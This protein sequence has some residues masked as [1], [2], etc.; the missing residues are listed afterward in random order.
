VEE[1]PTAL[2]VSLLDWSEWTGAEWR[3]LPAGRWPWL[4]V[5]KPGA[6]SQ[7]R[8]RLRPLGSSGSFSLVAV[9]GYSTAEGTRTHSAVTLGPLRVVAGWRDWF[10]PWAVAIQSVVVTLLL[11]ITLVLVAWLLPVME[12]SWSESRAQAQQTWN[13][14][15]PY[16]MQTGR[17]HYLPVASTLGWLSWSVKQPEPSSP[18]ERAEYR[19]EIVYYTLRFL[20][21]M[22]D[23]RDQLGGLHF[24]NRKGEAAAA[25]CWGSI[26]D[27]LSKRFCLREY[28]AA[29]DAVNPKD[30]FDRFSIRLERRPIFRPALRRAEA[31]ITDWL[32]GQSGLALKEYLPLLDFYRE[33]L[34]YEVNRPLEY[35]YNAPES[36]NDLR[37]AWEELKNK[38]YRE[39]PDW[40]QVKAILKTY[41]ELVTA[42]AS[43]ALL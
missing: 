22:R 30:S 31:I 39:I 29:L 34:R 1:L 18:T 13:L 11:P 19:R 8:C 36:S 20:R 42:E 21:Q 35:W 12:K 7:F 32:D 5:L 2:L 26:R 38:D 9:F 37:S 16:S 17:E 6:S 33:T 14:L 23:V 15:L 43:P 24:K 10:V 25:K 3:P 40:T 4:N 27:L 41:V 28:D